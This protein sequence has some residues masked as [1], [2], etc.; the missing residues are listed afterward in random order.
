MLELSNQNIKLNAIA[1]N[2]SDAIKLIAEGLTLN[3]NVKSDYLSGLMA[4]EEQTSTYLGNGIAIPH[5]TLDTRHLVEKTGVY[6]CQF[7]QGIQWGDET[8]Y[9]VIGIAAKSDEHLTLLR[10]LTAILGDE[11]AT[12]TLAKAQNLDEFINTLSGKKSFSIYNQELIS[13]NVETSSL[14][15]LS[16]V[17]AEKLHQQGYVDEH[18]VV[19]VINSKPLPL[20]EN[21]FITDARKG[22][23]VNGIALARSNSATLITVSSIDKRI[24]L[25]L[26]A[27]T[28]KENMQKLVSLSESELVDFLIKRNDL[29]VSSQDNT[30]TNE[31]SATFEVLNEHGIHARPSAML[32]KTARGF[33]SQILVQN[34]DRQTDLVNAKNIMKVVSIAAKKGHKIRFVATGEDAQQALDAIG[35]A[36]AEKLGEK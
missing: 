23:K 28:V 22:N 16:A 24:N 21:L 27:L 20:T 36:M 7:P 30:S 31:L 11:N 32:V 1:Q 33:E 18:F 8:A 19:D 13:C 25:E 29:Q 17:N 6:V 35:N 12:N 15:T 9:V 3:G 10:Q 4:R 26:E 34:L 14:I 5:G 2:K